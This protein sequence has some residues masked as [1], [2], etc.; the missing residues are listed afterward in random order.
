M[1]ALPNLLRGNSKKEKTVSRARSV[2]FWTS[3]QSLERSDKGKRPHILFLKFMYC[4][5]HLGLAEF[6]WVFNY[7]YYHHFLQHPG[8]LQVNCNWKVNILALCC[9]EKLLK[10]TRHKWTIGHNTVMFVLTSFHRRKVAPEIDGIVVA[11]FFFSIRLLIW[12][13]IRCFIMLKIAHDFFGS[14]AQ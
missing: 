4:H 8:A 14:L 1:A 5:K 9:L 6:L 3:Y 11:V 12:I 7:F 10:K 13:H 2:T